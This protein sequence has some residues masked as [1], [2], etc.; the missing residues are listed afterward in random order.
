MSDVAIRIAR[1][2]DAPA[3][4]AIYAP[5]VRQTHISFETEPPDGA[6]MARRLQ[7]TLAT[8][9][10]LAAQSGGAVIGYAYARAHR[11]R[12]AYRWSVDVTIYL[13]EAARRRGVGRALYLALFELL[14]RQGFRSA[15]AGVALPNDASVGL[16]EALGFEPVGVYRDVGFKLGA[17]RD[18]GWW[19]LGLSDS[20]QAP[21]EPAAFADLVPGL[22]AWLG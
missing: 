14:R 11:A 16:H 5:I 10:W 9:P 21:S 22:P 4:A 3:M 13:G 1:A 17:W 6:E 2:D 15:F 20:A 18:V 19:R 8:H 12:A 7:A